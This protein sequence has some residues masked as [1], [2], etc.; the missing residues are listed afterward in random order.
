MAQPWT[1]ESEARILQGSGDIRSYHFLAHDL[2]LYHR[3]GGNPI[4]DPWNL[5]PVIRPMGY[6]LFIAFW[7]WLFTPRIWIP[8]LAQVFLSIFSIILV[9]RL[10]YREFGQKAA[11]V[12]SLLFALWPNGILFASTLMTETLYIFIMLCFLYTW[13]TLKHALSAYKVLP[14]GLLAVLGILFGISVYVRVSTVYFILL[15]PFALWFMFKQ[16][17]PYQR[18]R[19]ILTFCISF[20]ITIMPYSLYMYQR[21]G[22]FRMTMVDDHNLL[23]NT[24]SHGLMGRAGRKDS[25]VVEHNIKLENELDRRLKAAGLDPVNS[26]PFD[27]SP[28]FRALAWEYF[29]KHPVELPLGMLRGMLRFWLWPDRIWEIANEVLP[30]KL[31]LR[32]VIIGASA[33]YAFSFH[34]LWLVLL[35]AGLLRAAKHH[36]D[37]FWMFLVA[38]LYFTLVTSSAGNDRYRMQTAAFAF[39]LTGLGAVQF[40]AVRARIGAKHTPSD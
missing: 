38:A 29:R 40:A 36:K 17:Y 9:Y 7:Y 37:W 25:R 30:S 4:A 21:Y 3:Y 13:S 8:L 11:K 15:I 10:V 1:A 26:N 34:A 16:F 39:P 33:A 6:V 12:T 19:I 24:I 5:D 2:V 14:W 18:I 35:G 22:T 32:G 28:Y 20:L 27:R 23:Y 31:P